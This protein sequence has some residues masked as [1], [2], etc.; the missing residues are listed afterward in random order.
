MLRS[1]YGHLR[2]DKISSD[3]ARPG[4]D[5]V[6]VK[7]GQIKFRTRSSQVRSYPVTSGQGVSGHVRSMSGPVRTGQSRVMSKSGQSQAKVGSGN[8]KLRSRSDKEKVRSGQVN[9]RSRPCQDQVQP[10]SAQVTSRQ[11]KVGASSCQA[12]PGQV[13]GRVMSKSSL[14]KVR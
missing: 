2:S 1:R 11:F 7:P 3:Q 4:Q 13:V 9:V 5:Q 14:S 8:V 6:K 12:W 10:K